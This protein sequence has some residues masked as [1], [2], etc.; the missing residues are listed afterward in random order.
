MT[1]WMNLENTVITESKSEREVV[2]D[3]LRPHGW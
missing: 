1:A 3:S 2:S